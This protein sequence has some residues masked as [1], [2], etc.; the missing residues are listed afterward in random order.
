MFNANLRFTELRLAPVAMADEPAHQARY[1]DALQ[2]TAASARQPRQAAMLATGGLDVGSV[3][4]IRGYDGEPNCIQQLEIADRLCQEVARAGLY[5]AD[6][7]MDVCVRAEKD[8]R[9]ICPDL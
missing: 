2:N 1:P 5:G 4:L 7:R 9:D 8:E 3:L 6:C